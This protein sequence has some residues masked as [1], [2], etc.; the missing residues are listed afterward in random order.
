MVLLTN[1]LWSLPPVLMMIV[2]LLLIGLSFRSVVAPIRAVVSLL[3]MLVVT[4]GV[5]VFTFQDNAFGFLHWSQLGARSTG[6]MNWMSPCVAFS[7]VVGLGLDYD[8]FFS[9][10]VAEER[11]NGYSNKVAI[12]RALA[13]TANTISAAGGT[14]NECTTLLE[15]HS[16]IYSIHLFIALYCFTRFAH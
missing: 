7:V 12:V 9:E 10:R 11:E 6:A 2:V 1:L 5:A 13:A 15:F 16:S 3:W 14:S 4:F 8:I